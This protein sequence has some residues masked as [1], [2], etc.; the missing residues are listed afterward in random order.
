[1]I[2]Y[3]L[4]GREGRRFSPYCWRTDM[5][6]H[7]KGL[8]AERVAV[9][10]AD[11][12]PLDFTDYKKV[13]VLVDGE[14]TVVESFDIAVYLDETYPDRPPLMAGPEA[15]GLARFVNEWADRV[16]NPALV[17]IIIADILDD[18]T[19]A[20]QENFRTTRE[21]RFGCSLEEVCGDLEARLATFS[22]ALEP[23]RSTLRHQDYLSGSQPGY[24]D[25]ILFGCLQWA[26]CTSAVTLIPADD[27]VYGWREKLL[28]MFDGYA[29]K[30]PGHAV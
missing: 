27:P 16:V 10:F 12:S 5:A 13:P 14:K 6:L 15:R 25:Y 11:K 17:P 28:D 2:L 26:R 18:A 1:M 30:A 20:D 9:G 8:T 22:K 19:E 7:H 4:D 21:A 3:E 24:A 29:R 23:A